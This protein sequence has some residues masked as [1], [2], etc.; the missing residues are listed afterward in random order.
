MTLGEI[1]QEACKKDL[2]HNGENAISYTET[3]KGE[4]MTI[5]LESKL[6][7]ESFITCSIP[8]HGLDN[9]ANYLRM[10]F[11]SMLFNSSIY[12]MKRINHKKGKKS[13]NNNLN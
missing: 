11:L 4:I 8:Y 12:G 2:A 3:V 10:H 13:R 1:L 9:E 7:P 5:K 6:Y